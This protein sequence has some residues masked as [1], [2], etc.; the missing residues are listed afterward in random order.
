[1]SPRRGE[2][3]MVPDA[4]FTSYYGRPIL[5]SPTW[6]VPDVPLYLYLGGAAGTSACLGALADLTG[7][8]SLRRWGRVGA[9]TGALVSV[10]A[11]VHDLGRPRRFLHM[12]RVLKPTSPMSVG[13]W[14]LAGY[15]PLAGIAAAGAV[16]G[17]APRIGAA[18]T[19]GAAVL[20]PAVAAYT[21]ALIADTAVPAW[22]DG[23]R[24]LPYVF[25]GSAATAAGG[26]GL[27]AAP[28]ADHRPARTLA[29]LGVAGELTVFEHMTRRM[30][31]VGEPYRTGSS[32]K[33]I[34]AGEVL[35]VGGA[36]GAVLGRRRRLTAALSGAALLAASACTR[37]GIFAAGLA[38]ARDPRYTV[39][40]QRER[41]RERE[42]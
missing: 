41:L 11:L 28:V 23:H 32:G 33:L 14:L 12:L 34:R 29:L 24:E 39:E 31:L 1:M 27:L 42:D 22:H 17:R 15:A 19:G 30:G 35:A 21:A 13:S 3:L 2:R 8:G 10:G 16:T 37:F 7:R 18:A 26:L 6:K 9:L 5:K 36:V 4:E 20:G 38:S 25:V 40:P